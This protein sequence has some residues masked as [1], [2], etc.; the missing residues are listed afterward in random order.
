[1][2]AVTSIW[3]QMMARRL[4]PLALLL[5]AGVPRESVVDEYVLSESKQEIQRLLAGLDPDVRER[6][7][8]FSR[9]RPETIG[10]ALEHL[11]ATYGC[12]RGYLRGACTTVCSRCNEKYPKLSGER[13]YIGDVTRCTA[14]PP[15]SMS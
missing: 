1:M 10:T 7:E 6:A 5:V 15:A 3:R 13:W 14:S 2:N 12:V 9:S 11:D 4:W 8:A